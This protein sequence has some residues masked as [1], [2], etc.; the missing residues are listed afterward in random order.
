MA[1][2]FSSVF[3]APGETLMLEVIA[4]FMKSKVGFFLKGLV[5]VFMG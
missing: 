4:T 5:D 3:D 1:R 2:Y